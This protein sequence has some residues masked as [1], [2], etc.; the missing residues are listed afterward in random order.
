M[1]LCATA[2]LWL[3]TPGSLTWG[4]RAGTPGKKKSWCWCCW[5]TTS[6]KLGGRRE[7]EEEGKHQCQSVPGCVSE[8][9]GSNPRGRTRGKGPEEPQR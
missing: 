1:A 7:M 5:K 2:P 8:H 6:F 3:K 9:R 4:P